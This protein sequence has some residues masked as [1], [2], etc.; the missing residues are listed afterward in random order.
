MGRPPSCLA[1]RALGL[2]VVW[3]LAAF[4]SQLGY[5]LLDQKDVHASTVIGVAGI[6]KFFGKLFAR[7][8]GAVDIQR[9][10][11]IDDRSTP[12]EL[13]AFGFDSG[14]EDRSYLPLRPKRH[15]WQGPCDHPDRAKGCNFANDCLGNHPHDSAETARAF[16][17]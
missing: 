1:K 11:Q 2:D 7:T 12:F 14:I 9:L 5:D 17:D 15:R 3:Q 6:A 16:E 13:F 8:E 10:H 4:G